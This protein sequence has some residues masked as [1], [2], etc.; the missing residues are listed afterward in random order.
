M[1]GLGLLFFFFLVNSA[2]IM[3]TV[4]NVQNVAFFGDEWQKCP[5]L[6]SEA[7]SRLKKR[8]MEW[9]RIDELDQRWLREVG[10]PRVFKDDLCFEQLEPSTVVRSSKWYGAL[11][12]Q[13]L[14]YPACGETV[15]SLEGGLSLPAAYPLTRSLCLVTFDY[16]NFHSYF[17][18]Y[19]VHLI[20]VQQSHT[21]FLFYRSIF[22]FKKKIL[23]LIL[24]S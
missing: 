24:K 6:P 3:Y 7:L 20:K 18:L 22:T 23:L 19:K 9:A 2:L 17:Q 11:F 10:R 14:C 5:Q 8:T 1:K 12:P 4:I 13:H 16:E 15:T 21:L